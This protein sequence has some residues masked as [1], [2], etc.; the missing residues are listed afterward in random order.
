MLPRSKLCG[1]NE[2]HPSTLPCLRAFRACVITQGYRSNR[3]N[4]SN[5]PSQDSLNPPRKLDKRERK[6]LLLDLYTLSSQPRVVQL[7]APQ[8]RSA[9]QLPAAQIRSAGQLPS[10]QIRS[11]GQLPAAQIRSADQLPTAQEKEFSPVAMSSQELDQQDLLN[12]LDQQDRLDE[13]DQQDLPYA[14]HGNAGRLE[15][16]KVGLMGCGS[17]GGRAMGGWA[18]GY[19]A[20][21]YTSA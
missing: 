14:S 16:W 13:L 20:M 4:Q 6:D 17:V 18:M 21:C 5:R 2:S 12:E 19:A 10:A 11:A 1:T 3:S 9:D 15:Q 8:I 7:P